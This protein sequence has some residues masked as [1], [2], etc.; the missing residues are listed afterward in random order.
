MSYAQVTTLSLPRKESSAATSALVRSLVRF[1]LCGAAILIALMLDARAESC[2]LATEMDASLKQ[3]LRTA[4]TQYFG[5]VAA[6][7]VQAVA[8]NSIPEIAGNAQGLT[9]LLQQ[10]A[11]DLAGATAEPRSTFFLDATG[12][13]ATL[14]NA[15]FYCGV[16][17]PSSDTKIGF[18]LNN[19][20]A[21]KYGLVI[22]DVKNSQTPYF[23]SFL[24][25]QE[26]AAWKIAAL[27]PRNRT[28]AGRDAQWYWQEARNYKAQGKNHNAWFY[29]L[30]AREIASPLPFI[31]TTKLDSFYEEVNK[32]E[33][34]DL[35]EKNPIV[36]TAN[37]KQFQVTSIFVVPDDKQP[38]L[39]LVMKY[40]AADI[41]DTAKTFLDNKDAMKA[42]L[43]KYPELREPFQNLV[44]RAVAPSGQDFGS[45]LPMKDIQ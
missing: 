40:N 2:Q 26:P 32:S 23:Y 8:Q 41:S 3:Q 43:T 29:Y 24:L 39:N 21:G 1:A 30:I 19:L 38:I 12:G 5:Y 4:A 14:Q 16:F 25:K 11:K 31:G 13:E 42:L 22:L 34:S 18:S 44:A 37:G 45:M 17:N 35:P 15:Q 33:P 9:N 6:G 36:L 28:I 7:N 10:N 20:P 27:F